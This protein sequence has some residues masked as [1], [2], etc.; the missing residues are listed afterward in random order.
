M[1]VVGIFIWWA[2][3]DA[4]ANYR[5]TSDHHE[6][7]NILFYPSAW[8][9]KLISGWEEILGSECSK[10]IGAASSNI[11]SSRLI[12]T[13]LVV[14]AVSNRIREMGRLRG[15][16][17]KFKR[18]IMKKTRYWI[19]KIEYYEKLISVWVRRVV[20]TL[21]VKLFK[22]AEFAYI[23]FRSVLQKKNWRSSGKI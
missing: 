18:A 12:Q 19:D 14:I 22:D 17:L 7:V 11:A 4:E 16:I 15:W 5:R 6:F 2:G 13:A 20:E 23:D 3:E 9:Q 21:R 8:K 10:I 1:R